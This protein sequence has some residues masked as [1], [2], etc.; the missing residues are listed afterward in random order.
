MELK[1]II[2]ICKKCY[3]CETV[4]FYNDET[5]RYDK[6]F[7]TCNEDWGECEYLKYWE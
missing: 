3:Y 2:H 1:D 6:E 7:L 5:K 4:Y